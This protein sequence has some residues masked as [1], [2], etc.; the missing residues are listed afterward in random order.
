MTNSDFWKPRT[1]EE[2]IDL[3]EQ[4]IDPEGTGKHTE[5]LKEALGILKGIK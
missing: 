5:L 1:L 3:L 2:A 4:A